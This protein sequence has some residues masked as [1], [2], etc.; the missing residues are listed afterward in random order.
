MDFLVRDSFHTG[1]GYGS[2][3]VHRL[4]YTMDV[5]NGNL[6][7]DGRAVAT[8]ESFLLARLESFR[9]IYFHRASRAVQ[10]KIVQALEAAMDDLDLQVFISS[11][12]VVWPVY[13]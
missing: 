10:I 9:T 3:D 2:V 8:L 5:I 11:Q 12:R 6:S 1:A 4:L 7:V 13:L